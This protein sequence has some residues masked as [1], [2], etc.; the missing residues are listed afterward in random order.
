MGLEWWLL[1]SL[2]LAS[3]R[4]VCQRRA[5]W[6]WWRWGPGL[7]QLSPPP[8]GTGARL[9]RDPGPAVTAC[10]PLGP[11]RRLRLGS[12]RHRCWCF[13]RRW[14]CPAPVREAGPRARRLA[15]YW[16]LARPGVSTWVG[17]LRDPGARHVSDSACFFCGLRS[18]FC[19]FPCFYSSPWR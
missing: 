17:W 19:C 10:H 9:A 18:F 12:G 3:R 5:G 15:L 13:G 2:A 8:S 1:A 6:Y 16:L 14:W 11:C 7:L 4:L